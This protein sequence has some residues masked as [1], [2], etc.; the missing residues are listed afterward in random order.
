M[1]DRTPPLYDSQRRALEFL[2]THPQAMLAMDMGT[3]K[4]LSDDTPLPTDSGQWVDI[5]QVAVGQR[6]LDERN[7]P[8]EVTAVFPQGEVPL[9]QVTFDY[10][11]TVLADGS[12]Q[13]V[14]LSKQQVRKAQRSAREAT[15]WALGR[16]TLTTLEIM[17][18]L[19]NPGNAREH[20]VPLAKSEQPA[21]GRPL[22]TRRITGVRYDR[23]GPATCVTVDSPSGMYLCSRA[24]IPTHNTRVAV[25]RMRELGAR[26][27]LILGPL[28]AIDDVWENEIAKY[29]PDP[30]PHVIN[31]GTGTRDHGGRGPGQ[32]SDLK[33]HKGARDKARYGAMRLE[34]A[35]KRDQTVTL[36]NYESLLRPELSEWAQ[37]VDWDMVVMDESQR[38]KAPAG[39]LGREVRA[40][41]LA[42]ENR[43]A[44]TGTPM[45]Q[46]PLDIWGQFAALDPDIF[47]TSYSRFRNLYE[48]TKGGRGRHDRYR[49]LDQL[50]MRYRSIS[51][52]G[53]IAE[54][55]L[56]EFHADKRWITIGERAKRVHDQLRRR[57]Q[58]WLEGGQRIT[59]AGVLA[60][61][62]RMRQVTS[63]Y[64][65]VDNEDYQEGVLTWREEPRTKLLRIDD[66][67][68][69]HLEQILEDL[70]PK[71]KVVVFALFRH[72][73]EDIAEAAETAGRPNH[74]YSG[75]RKELDG[76][77]VSEGGVLAAQ[78]QAGS[79][80]VSMTEARYCIYYSLGY[81]ISDHMQS[82][83][84]VNRGGQERSGYYI[85]LNARNTVDQETMRS[86][87]QGEETV[88]RILER[89]EIQI[90]LFG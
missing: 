56:P 67:K 30:Q 3:G 76:W 63:G 50:I 55:N 19:N 74:E 12:H 45:P 57:M 33:R 58:A 18:Q 87:E 16:K 84:R 6:L 66:A 71:E 7:R 53:R 29:W 54:L 47:G 27:N 22:A 37:A 34:R 82:R 4:A 88:R 13:W 8:C 10:R 52:E 83:A 1:N 60:R 9:Y 21:A 62:T 26:H 31:L 77:R 69:R 32:R 64:A 86:L 65:A 72:D 89:R 2:R 51:C 61:L 90:P 17:E 20:H 46:G 44:L 41:S 75:T 49:N 11:N 39:R 14:T 42:A 28:P 25:E 35:P 5:G 68:Q 59:A 36:L 70:D 15:E 79:V 40:L 23:T 43:M 78:M 80:A 24:L 81:S 85:Y 48:G 73:L 38:I